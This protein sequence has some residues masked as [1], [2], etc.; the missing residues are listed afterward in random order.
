MGKPKVG[1][2]AKEALLMAVSM[3]DRR[4]DRFILTETNLP[5]NIVN[6]LVKKF[7]ACVSTSSTL[8]PIAPATSGVKR[9]EKPPGSPSSV[10]GESTSR[11]SSTLAFLKVLKFCVAFVAASSDRGGSEDI[12]ALI[13]IEED[14]SSWSLQMTVCDHFREMFLVECVR[15]HLLEN[16]EQQVL[17]VQSLFRFLLLDLSPTQKVGEAS[18]QTQGASG[19]QLLCAMATEMICEDKELLNAIL[20]R[21]GSVSRSGLFP[22]CPQLNF[23]SIHLHYS[24]SLNLTWS[25]INERMLSIGPYI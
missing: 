11:S 20:P 8:T 7:T 24:A 9:D 5:R 6:E 12:E 1:I 13:S 25:C 17:I 22:F 19:A 14:P 10:G 23:D 18:V 4:V 15:P 2:Q 3:H 21:A 16:G